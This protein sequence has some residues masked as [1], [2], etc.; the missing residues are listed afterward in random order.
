MVE[1]IVKDVAEAGGDNNKKPGSGSDLSKELAGKQI[2]DG[3]NDSITHEQE[4][5]NQAVNELIKQTSA[6]GGRVGGGE[7]VK[8]ALSAGAGG[9]KRTNPNEGKSPFVEHD[10]EKPLTK[11]EIIKLIA[12]AAKQA[13]ADPAA[14]KTPSAQDE[15]IQKLK[16]ALNQSGDQIERLNKAIQ[17]INKAHADEKERIDLGKAGEQKT[18]FTGAKILKAGGSILAAKLAQNFVGMVLG[19]SVSSLLT[20]VLSAYTMNQITGTPM[21]DAMMM[22]YGFSMM[23]NMMGGGRSGQS[24]PAAEAVPTR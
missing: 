24:A 15:E 22:T 21:K 17:N 16:E 11:D 2:A 10:G 6:G 3:N 14:K 12:E 7:E 18:M 5:H 1:V 13:F 4:K 9:G 20:P 8:T 19:E 23:S